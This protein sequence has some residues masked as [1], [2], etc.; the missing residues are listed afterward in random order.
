M[1]IKLKNEKGTF[2]IG[3][4]DHVSARLQQITGLGL[5]SKEIQSLTY[6]HM[7][8][9]VITSERESERTI[10]LK[11]DY[12][13]DPETVIRFF[14]I[15][16]KPMKLELRRNGYYREIDCRVIAGAENNNIVYHHWEEMTLQLECSDPY[17]RGMVRNE[18]I[19][20]ATDML[21]NV[22]ENSSWYIQLPTVAT[23]RHQE[24]VIINDGDTIVYPIITVSN[25]ADVTGT[26]TDTVTITVNDRTLRIYH[27][28]SGD[29][30]M[31]FDLERRIITSSSDG[32]ITNL[33]SD[34]TVLS[35]MY[36]AEGRNL[37]TVYS[38]LEEDNLYAASSYSPRYGMAVI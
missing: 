22:S 23:V 1:I 36:Y 11:F 3:G 26:D 7:P 12:Y 18:E 28:V 29:E 34:D 6:S 25:L 17:F 5:V 37:I 19:V 38:S 2:E 8:G 4:G 24:I 9:R 32:D 33:I 10:T 14:K 13:A 30:T 35:D 16:Q 20:S 15:I 27:H 21:P 31:T